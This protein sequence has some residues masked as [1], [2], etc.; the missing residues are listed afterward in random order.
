MPALNAQANPFIL[1][2]DPQAVLSQ[3]EHS[4]RLERLH[5]RICRPLDRPLLSTSATTD[6]TDDGVAGDD[7]DPRHAAN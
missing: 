2:L 5:S 3:I 4:E 6:E 1:M 7:A